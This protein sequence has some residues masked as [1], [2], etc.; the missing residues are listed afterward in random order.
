MLKSYFFLIALIISDALA[1]SSAVVFMYH[2]FGESRYPST[3][4]TLKQ[5]EYQ[6]NYLEKNDYNV[7]P[8]SKIAEHIKQKKELPPK[9]VGLSIDDAYA[10]IYTG[11]YPLLKSRNFPFTVF[12]NT[13]PVDNRS[14][15]Y[16][17]W[18]NMR[19]M[20]KHGAEF[21]NHSLSHDYFLPKKDESEDACTQRVTRDIQAAQK[22]LQEELGEETN[23]NPKLFSFPFGEYSEKTA[24]TIASLG[25]IGFTQ[26]S[27][28]I[29]F[30]SDTKALLRFPMAERYAHKKG[31]LTKLNTL[32]LPVIQSAPYEPI[33][34]KNNPPRFHMKLKH[35]VR[36]LGCY[37]SNGDRLDIEW[38][39]K[40]E[41]YVSAK[42]PLKAPRDRYACTAP[43]PDGKIYWYS[44][45]WIVK[46]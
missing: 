21:A 35:P 24:N 2:R 13:N 17:T 45:L 32:P 29:G 6:L 37:L 46:N 43:A 19:E 34:T 23:E 33:L 20:S 14:K 1:S 28:A 10:S 41:L 36:A 12:V 4:I 8:L 27:G 25:Y 22:R 5:F 40:T 9:T 16:L 7:W 39:S 44:H 15:A 18:D 30:E 38:V 11:A 26:A 31:F 3:N 42:K